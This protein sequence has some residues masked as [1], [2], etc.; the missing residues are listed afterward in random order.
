MPAKPRRSVTPGFVKTS[1]E[2]SEAAKYAL[3]DLKTALRREGYA[4]LAE[5]AIVEA[6]FMTAKRDGVD[7]GVLDR[8][9][10]SRAAALQRVEKA[11]RKT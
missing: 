4:G 10:R 2:V 6:L 3:E 5:A 9:I 7:R 11:R 1:F 8:V